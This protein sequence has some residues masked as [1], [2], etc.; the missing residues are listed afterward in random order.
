MPPSPP[1]HATSRPR[2]PSPSVSVVIPVRD[3]A[4]VPLL[5][6]GLPPVDEVIVVTAGPSAATVAAIR[7]ARP[8]ALL[9]HPLRPG[10]GAALAAGIAASS[11]EVVV[12]LNGDGSTDPGDIPRYLAA[13]RAGADVVLGSRYRPGGRDLTGGRFRRRADLLLIWVVNA[14]FGTRR[15]DPGFGCAALW[16][17][18]ARRL[19]L[20]DP[21]AAEPAW[22]DGPEIGPLLTLRP[23]TLGLVLAEIGG[24]AYPRLRRTD[25][26]DRATVRHWLRAIVAERRRPAGTAEPGRDKLRRRRGAHQAEVI[27]IRADPGDA[28][29]TAW[30]RTDRQPAEPLW[31]PPR[32]RAAP[33]AGDLWRSPG[34][35]IGNAAVPGEN[36]GAVSGRRRRTT[37]DG[38]GGKTADATGGGGKAV[39]RSGDPARGTGGQPE[40][41]GWLSGY[42]L[43]G[44]AATTGAGASDVKPGGGQ[45]NPDTRARRIA[46]AA[47]AANRAAGTGTPPAEGQPREVGAR[48]R[49]LES[50]RQRPDLHVINGEGTGNRGPGGRLRAVPGEN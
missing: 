45:R 34:R 49:R 32:R 33:P 6:R 29:A 26:A 7:A 20:P 50:F 41:Q 48:R 9:V 18:A 10:P 16:R 37:R 8:D 28:R 35:P 31:G 3:A 46:G 12:A 13:L 2:H 11:G 40:N 30:P 4:A 39:G 5:L 36:R 44:H 23:A 22:G 1:P 47:G 43:R 38:T 21:G 25:G 17:D 27:A 24:V 19:D 42:P 15:T 14:L